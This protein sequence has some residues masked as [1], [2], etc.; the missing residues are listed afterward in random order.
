MMR[1]AAVFD[2]DGTV[3]DCLHRID[4]AKSK[5][6]DEFHS[7]C[8][9]DTPFM[10]TMTLIEAI[11]PSMDIIMATGR[12]NRY[13]EHTLQTFKAHGI[14][15]DALLMRPDNDF[16]PDGEMKL[17]LLEKH[18]GSKEKVLEGVAFVLDDRDKVVE[19]FRN[20]GLACWQVRVGDY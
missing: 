2:L 1:K 11:G 5:Q 3:F 7:R 15:C 19:A 6:W 8:T 14:M 20:Y 17:R 18:F 10:D 9:A 16:S 12:T 13:R 4:Y